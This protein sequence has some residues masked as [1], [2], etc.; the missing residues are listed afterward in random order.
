MIV[1]E[2]WAVL[3]NKWGEWV[4]ALKEIN[5]VR[6]NTSL[7]FRTSVSKQ[8]AATSLG[9]GPWLPQDLAGNCNTNLSEI[10]LAASK[11]SCETCEQCFNTMA[12]NREVASLPE[13][14]YCGNED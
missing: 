2:S 4:G 10:Q 9:A 13:H 11:P 8:G 5:S 3:R 1:Y 14:H 6:E 12:L 7:Q